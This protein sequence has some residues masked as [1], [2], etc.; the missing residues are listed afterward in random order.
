MKSQSSTSLTSKYFT[1][2][3]LSIPSFEN[4]S[5][6]FL[7]HTNNNSFIDLK[8]FLLISAPHIPQYALRKGSEF[9]TQYRPQQQN[10]SSGSNNIIQDWWASSKIIIN[11]KADT[12]DRVKKIKRPVYTWKNCFTKSMKDI[13]TT[14]LLE[15]LINLTEDVKPVKRKAPRYTTKERDFANK[16]F[17]VIEN[18]S[19]IIN[20]ISPW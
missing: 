15:H 1:L 4:P 2:A 8:G 19:I 7:L 5:Y 12:P 10:L 18:A 16:I 6:T 14:N 3:A 13:Y 11:L 17:P 20:K 9:P